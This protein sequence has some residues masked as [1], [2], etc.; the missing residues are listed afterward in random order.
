MTDIPNDELRSLPCVTRWPGNP[1]LTASQVP[2]DSALVFN[3]GV[4]RW[5]DGYAV[6]FRNDYG[7]TEAEWAEGK[8]FRGTNIGLA[9]SR[10]GINWKVE[11][12][13]V[14]HMEDA[15]IQRVYDPRLTVIGGEAFMTFAVDTHHGLR[16]GIAR[17]DDLVHYEVVSMSVPDNR[18]MVLFPEKINGMYLRLERPM[19]VY[20]RGGKDRFDIWISESPDL[21][22][23]GRSELLA[24]VEDFPWANDKIGPGA[25]PVK[26]DRGWLVFTHAVDRDDSRG[27]HGWENK[28]PKRYCAGVMLLDLKDPRR[29]LGVCRRPL[30]A[31][32][33]PY[34]T[35]YGFRTNTVF[36]TAA[37][38]EDEGTVKIYYG[39]ADTSVALATARAEDLIQACLEGGPRK[40]V[41]LP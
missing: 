16:G 4:I 23:W 38:L 30:I 33:A 18:N 28:W 25:P 7:C 37:I 12:E 15:E 27:K 22:Y 32:E 31:P 36:P 29:V 26:T 20:S 2:Y 10:D 3:A 17:T 19:P 39:A 5:R 1:V 9:F 14:F 8:R 34:E 13:P 24:G 6:A 35:E 11:D 41:Q 40:P 21:V